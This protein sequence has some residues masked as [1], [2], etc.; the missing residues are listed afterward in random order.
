[1]RGGHRLHAEGGGGGGFEVYHSQ[2]WCKL[3]VAGGGCKSKV[4]G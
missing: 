2:C 4:H 3:Q 1:M